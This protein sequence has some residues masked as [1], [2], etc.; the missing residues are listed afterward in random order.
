MG[1]NKN[2]G[3][4]YIYS[5]EY[6]TEK[7]SI[8]S[9]IDEV[10]TQISET[11]TTLKELFIPDDYLGNKLKTKLEK[12]CLDLDTDNNNL[13]LEKGNIDTFINE[14]I[15]EHHRHYD[16]WVRNQELLRQKSNEESEG[17]EK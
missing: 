2:E 8:D 17:E 6:P 3:C 5:N 16:D 1:C 4:K 15:E 7:S 11:S 10:T 9:A 12:L 13:L 14:K